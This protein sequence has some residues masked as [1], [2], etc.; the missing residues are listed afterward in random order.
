MTYTVT[1]ML[2]RCHVVE[3]DV[4]DSLPGAADDAALCAELRELDTALWGW[5]T[6]GPRLAAWRL[7]RLANELEDG[8]ADEM[9]V[10]RIRRVVTDLGAIAITETN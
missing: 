8:T 1:L 7:R 5:S 2:N 9:P 6:T 3:H 10:D 4:A